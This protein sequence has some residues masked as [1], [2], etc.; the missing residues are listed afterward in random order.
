MSFFEDKEYDNL[1]WLN[2]AIDM[3]TFSLNDRVSQLKDEYIFNFDVIS[4]IHFLTIANMLNYCITIDPDQPGM[5]DKEIKL[6]S[7]LYKIDLKD[8]TVLN[9][10]DGTLSHPI[11]LVK[12]AGMFEDTH[13]TNIVV[14]IVRRLLN[15][16]RMQQDVSRLNEVM[17]IIE[18]KDMRKSRSLGYK[19]S[20]IIEH[21]T[22]IVREDVWKIR[23]MDLMIKAAEW[24]RE[25]TW[26]GNLAAIANLTKLKCMTHKGN[27]IY[28][29]KE[30]I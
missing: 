13:L 7:E 11:R 9:Y 12:T 20:A 25:F 10:E 4:R 3:P 27:P 23:N 29:M 26:T 6:A 22:H 18:C 17:D 8:G 5:P 24:I 2:A 1:D 21:F 19:Q 28:S 14:K 15:D 16:N 30:I